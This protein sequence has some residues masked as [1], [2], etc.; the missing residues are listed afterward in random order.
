VVL[1]TKAQNPQ[2]IASEADVVVACCGVAE[3]LDEKWIKDDAIVIDVGINTKN[4]ETG[5]SVLCGDVNALAVSEYAS[6][7][8]AVPGGIGSVTSALLF[9]NTLKGWYMVNNRKE[10]RFDFEV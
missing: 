4:D 6:L 3:L 10:L 1:H 8:T 9:A 7:V 2:E 5:K